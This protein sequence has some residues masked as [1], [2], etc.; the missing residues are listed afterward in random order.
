MRRFLTL[1]ATLAVGLT[2]L[3]P[4]SAQNTHTWQLKGSAGLF[5]LPDFVGLLVVGF[6]S[7]DTT[8]EV[9]RHEFTP[10]TN[11]SFEAHRFV[12]EWF[13]LGGSLSVGYA[14]AYTR[15]ANGGAISRR[16]SALYPTLC[17]AATTRYFE[18]NRFAMYGSWGVGATAL[19]VDQYSANSSSAN[20]D[21]TPSTGITLMGNLYPLCLSYGESS[22]I[23]VEVGWG[24]KGIVNVGGFFNF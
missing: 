17:L 20:D 18:S 23:Y 10:V 7:I 6:G 1:L 15:F 11:L 19:L 14:S 22:G 2:P 5:S 13:A 21:D 3:S 12:N 16:A 4:A 9:T 24:A 8:D